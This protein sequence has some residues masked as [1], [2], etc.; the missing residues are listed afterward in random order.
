M[1]ILQSLLHPRRKAGLNL[2]AVS[3]APQGHEVLTRLVNQ[4]FASARQTPPPIKVVGKGLRKGQKAVEFDLITPKG[5]PNTMRLCWDPTDLS[6]SSNSTKTQHGNGQIFWLLGKVHETDSYIR[7]IGTQPGEPT[8]KPEALALALDLKQ[9]FAETQK[10][11]TQV[12]RSLWETM[13]AS[14]WYK[15]LSV[16]I[17]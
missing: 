12:T 2:G 13:I 1:G 9:R 17:F 3:M 16:K 5:T 6:Y 10:I 14:Q 7:P 15:A 8:P 11:P 4:A